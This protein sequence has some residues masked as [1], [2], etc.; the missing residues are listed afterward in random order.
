MASASLLR[1][2]TFQGA[3]P[4]A[5]WRPPRRTAYPRRL[6]R[7]RRLDWRAVSALA[8]ASDAASP[9]LLRAQENAVVQMVSIG[10]VAEE[11]AV[12]FADAGHRLYLVG[13]S[14]R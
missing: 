13:G 10:P 3:V 8:T 1:R 6:A 2:A 14:V 12:R 7:K 9:D 11:L 4:L 5:V